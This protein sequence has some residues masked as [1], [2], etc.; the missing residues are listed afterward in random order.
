MPSPF[1]IEGF[2]AIQ[3]LGEQRAQNELAW[4]QNALA[5]RRANNEAERLGWERDKQPLLLK[6]LGQDVSHAGAMNPLNEQ[7]LRGDIS[8]RDQLFPY[9]LRQK[10]TATEAAEEAADITRQYRQEQG[11][12]VPNSA[13]RLPTTGASA[14][15]AAPP[16]SA[17]ASKAADFVENYVLKAPSD[18]A[19]AANFKEFTQHPELGPRWQ[20]HVQAFGTTGDWKRD[21][22]DFVRD[23]RHEANGVV[24]KPLAGTVVTPADSSRAAAPA[25]APAAPAAAPQSAPI[26]QGAANSPLFPSIGGAMKGAERMAA[27][28]GMASAA[29]AKLKIL[30]TMVDKGIMPTAPGSPEQV[31]SM[32][33]F[34]AAEG[35]KK[36]AESVGTH[37]GQNQAAVTESRRR[38]DISMGLLDQLEDL[39]K[40]AY[41]KD[42]ALLKAATG[43]Y[44]SGENV[45]AG[46]QGARQIPILGRAVPGSEE[47]F[48]LNK[49]MHHIIEGLSTQIK[50]AASRGV[51]TDQAQ[52]TFDSAIGKFMETDDPNTFFAI[53]HDA[54]NI[55]KGMGGD[56]PEPLKKDNNYLPVARGASAPQGGRNAANAQPAPAKVT[57]LP[58][59]QHARA[60]VEARE[61]VQQGKDPALVR[62]RLQQWGIDPVEAGF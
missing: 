60:I 42:P 34:P 15:P 26:Q 55:I 4:A 11:F 2:G 40:G 48:N 58:P 37:T 19:G 9:D 44:A 45:Q 28:P 20:Q 41:L 52:R 29:E 25:V 18:D 50:I 30:N 51:V 36:R 49:R 62:Q 21:A 3:R 23:M 1:A 12:A 39:A 56:M 57:Q 6:A 8:E 10:K 35:E 33:G 24:L 22:A 5:E 54:R 17:A 59:D 61:A 53:L 32:T 38:A 16:R 46:L 43:P 13:A 47:S 14:A 7:K 27:V 31:M